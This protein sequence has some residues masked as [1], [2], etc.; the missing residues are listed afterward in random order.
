MPVIS[1]KRNTDHYLIFPMVT[2]ASPESFLPGLSDANFTKAGY[3]KDGAA[4]WTS[5][6]PSQVVGALGSTGLYSLLLPAGEL[7]HDYV[8]VKLSAATAQDTFYSFRLFDKDIDA[9][10]DVSTAQVQASCA[11]ALAAAEVTSDLNALIAS[12]ATLTAA[13]RN[14]VADAIL[15]RSFDSAVA[16]G[17][18]ESLRNLLTSLYF[19][20]NKWFIQGT[21]LNVTKP[22]DSDVAWTATVTSSD[23]ATPVV[24]VDPA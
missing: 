2:A 8:G 1:H 21:T 9:L 15:G 4:A 14:A 10:N 11:A 5:F 7:D 17:A 6:T 16:A 19:L 20:R 18:S 13:E 12:G 22:N 23:A 24:G 3:F